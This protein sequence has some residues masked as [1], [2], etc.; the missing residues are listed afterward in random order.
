LGNVSTRHIGRI[1]KGIAA[2]FIAEKINK[3]VRAPRINRESEFL[4]P[5]AVPSKKRNPF[6]VA[7]LSRPISPTGWIEERQGA[8]PARPLDPCHRWLRSRGVAGRAGAALV[9]GAGV[10]RHVAQSILLRAQAPTPRASSSGPT[11]EQVLE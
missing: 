9:R 1:G 4:R 8:K 3:H 10:A 2:A 7:I 11:D 5:I 6:A